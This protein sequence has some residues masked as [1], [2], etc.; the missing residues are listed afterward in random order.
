[1]NETTRDRNTVLSRILTSI[2]GREVYLEAGDNAGEYRQQVVAADPWSVLHHR[3]QITTHEADA[4]KVHSITWHLTKLV[5]EGRTA[6]EASIF[7]GGGFDPASRMDDLAMIAW[8]QWRDGQACMPPQ[9]RAPVFN[10]VAW[11]QYPREGELKVVRQ[12]LRR[13]VRF[14]RLRNGFEDNEP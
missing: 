4:A 12:G 6:I 10:M 5:P 14:Y 8:R 1:M 3:G 13:L 7:G 11:H 9:C 2:G